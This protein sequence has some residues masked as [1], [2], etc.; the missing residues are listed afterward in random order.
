MRRICVVTGSRAEFGLLHWGMREIQQ[1]R[2]LEL[3]ILVTG[4]HLSEKYGLTYRE[5][6]KAGFEISAKV[7]MLESENTPEAVARSTGQGVIGCTAALE[8][9]Q[10]DWLVVLGDR[11]ETF[12]AVVAATFLKIPVA[13]FHGGETTE[14]AFD[15]ALRHSITKMAHLHFTSTQDYRR[16][17]IQLGESPER[18]HNVGAV[19]L[20][21]IAS[22]DLLNREELE[23][24]TGIKFREQNLL[25]TFHPV[26]LEN[27]T[28]AEQTDE[29]FKAL[30]SFSDFGL[31]I[32]H[33]NADPGSE[34]ILSKIQE[35]A[36]RHSDRVWSFASM[37]FIN[38]LSTLGMVDGVVGN[39]SSGL[40]EVPYF[41]I[42][43][44]NI[45]ERQKGRI[46]GESVIHCEPQCEA[47][48]EAIQTATSAAF[49]KKLNRDSN[50]YGKPGASKRAIEILA[51]TETRGILKKKFYDLP[52][53]QEQD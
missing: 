23:S 1:H 31:I 6:E 7:E 37:G 12:A 18:V 36:T 29:L 28:S 9:L 45:G 38:Y 44:V 13:H 16:R 19:G 35:F 17:V 8:K 10:P 22:C 32:T 52:E 4:M 43:T 11:F 47:I 3:Q 53:I 40:I 50:P 24:K 14:G 51:N 25:V 48:V 41:E 46:A 49:R 5:I 42:G 33:P 27:A 15:E 30:E 21:N 26:T 39:S 2:D 20:D 34:E